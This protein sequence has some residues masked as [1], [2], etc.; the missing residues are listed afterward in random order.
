M[1]LGGEHRRGDIVTSAAAAAYGALAKVSAADDAYGSAVLQAHRY[2]A[3]TTIWTVGYNYPLGPRDS[4]DV[5]WRYARSTPTTQVSP[6]LYPGANSAY[7]A[8]QYSI[9]YLVRF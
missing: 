8:N 4:I 9:A 1:Y 6:H 2:D 3:K 7:T 5:S